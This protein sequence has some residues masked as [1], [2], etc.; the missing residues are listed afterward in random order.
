MSL[1]ARTSWHSTC[2]RE[3][4]VKQFALCLL[5][6]V[7]FVTGPAV[8]QQSFQP[9]RVT[10][11]PSSQPVSLSA[12]KSVS[13]R[14]FGNFNKVAVADDKVIDATPISDT[15]VLIRGKEAGRTNII[16]Y[17]SGT[18]I[19]IVEVYVSLGLENIE[20]D[21]KALFPEHE[22]KLRRISSKIY[23]EGEVSDTVTRDR[24]FA[25]VDSYV[26]GNVINAISVKSPQQVALKV[27]FLEASRD[28]VKQI[29]FGNLISRGGDFAFL[30]SPNIISG[31]AP[32]TSGTLFG[33]SGSVTLDF[34]LSAL[35][36]K[37]II[38]T[39]AEPNLVATS[40]SEAS[41]LAGGEFPIPVAALDN[42]V[43][44]EFK[45]F[46]VSLDFKPQVLSRDRVSIHVLP[47]VSQVD[48]RNSIQ[49]SGFEI[50]S[51]IVRKADTTIELR[52]GQTFAIAG[53]LQNTYNNDVTQTPFMGDIPVIGALF[54]STRFRRNETEL[55]I[56][57]TPMLL[58]AAEQESAS[59]ALLSDP[60]E[61]TEAELIFLGKIEGM[62]G[63][64]GK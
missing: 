24:V 43:V 27:R 48:S 18:L 40:G 23:V 5:A 36:E 34:M 47:E 59:L 32:K 4:N 7:L 62:A 46:G 39:L 11:V 64:S 53:L 19:Q 55:I 29:G 22:F 30:T 33:G 44:I 2:Q 1:Q 61:P 38:R 50:P 56:L 13:V 17:R 49:V 37:G 31:A 35:E 14:T 3:S 57:V 28:T 54:R 9:D 21:L 58:N 42:R 41:F 26:P 10:G 25:V 20:A 60:V 45:E 52:H 16:F 15:E 8:A 12:G 6:L 63:N 51:L